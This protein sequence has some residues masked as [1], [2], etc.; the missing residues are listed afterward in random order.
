MNSSIISLH[1][2]VGVLYKSVV[3]LLCVWW[4]HSLVK[5]TRCVS[6]TFL[7]RI[8]ILYG[9]LKIYGKTARPLVYLLPVQW[10]LLL[11]G[12]RQ[13]LQVHYWVSGLQEGE[14]FVQESDWVTPL[15][16]VV[17]EQQISG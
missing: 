4:M 10:V 1:Y 6:Y 14:R 3:R 8:F 9:K 11:Y 5:K 7:L 16:V 12:L 17:G 13:H 15:F 2:I